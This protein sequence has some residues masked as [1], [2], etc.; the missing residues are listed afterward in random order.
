MR[1]AGGKEQG[2]NGNERIVRD[3]DVSGRAVVLILGPLLELGG[4]A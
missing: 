4:V 3:L 2:D 1:Q